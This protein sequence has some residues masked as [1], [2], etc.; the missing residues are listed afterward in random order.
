VRMGGIDFPELL[1]AARKEGN[2][3]VFAGAGVSIPPPSNYPDFTNLAIKVAGGA[4][5][6]RDKEPI[7][8]F[9]GRLHDR[10]VKVH[11][12][13]RQILTDPESKPNSLHFDLLRLFISAD[14]MR[15]VTTNFD[16]HFSTAV[17]EV[18]IDK[19]SCE[20]H[21]AP[22][23]PLGHSFSGIVYLHGGVN[24][25]PQHLVLTDSDFGRA[26]LTEGWARRFIQRV[27]ET[28]TVLFVGYSHNDP[29]MNYL[30]R[31]FTP[32][33]GKSRRF[34]LTPLGKEGSWEY[35]GIVPV[36][37]NPSAG[38]SP[39]SSLPKALSAWSEFARLGMLDKEHLIK[40]TV[41]LPP[42]IDPEVGD[43]IEDSLSE[44]STCRF[45]TRH[46]DSVPWLKWVE[47]K[48][49]LGRLFDPSASLTHIDEELAIWI[50]ENFPF[51]HAGETL[52]LIRRQ[53]QRL[54][55]RLWT[56]IA[57]KLSRD[58]SKEGN[59]EA[60]R[61]WVAVLI[62]MRPVGTDCQ[63]LEHL[64]ASFTFPDDVDVALL[65]F[66]YLTRPTL[67]LEHDLLR[68]LDETAP[69][70][71]VQF[72]IESYGGGFWLDR[73]WINFFEPNLSAL[74]EKL[75][76]IIASQFQLAY[77]LSQADSSI[78]GSWDTLSLSR[79]LI[80]QLD[81]GRLAGGLGVLIDAAFGVVKWN[82]ANRP[83]R[84]DALV[85]IWFSSDSFLLKRLAILAVALSGHWSGDRRLTW[86]L[87]NDL[88]YARG[89]K[90]E[91]FMILQG[92]YPLSSKDVRKEALVKVN[93]GRRPVPEGSENT[94]EY[95]K[96]NLIYWLHKSDPTCPL[97]QAAFQ[98]VQ[99][100]NPNFGT[101]EHPDLDVSFHAFQVALQSPRSVEELL[102]N[103]PNTQIDFLLTYVS[104]TPFG[105]NREGLV[106]NVSAAAIR[107]YEWSRQL[108]GALLARDAIKAD[109][110]S[111]LVRAWAASELRNDAWKEVLTL[112]DT[113][114]RLHDSLASEIANLLEAGIKK[115][116]Q[117]IPP[118]CFDLI[119]DLSKRLWATLRT[120]SKAPKP[121]SEKTD[122]VM[123]AIN[124]PA[125]RLTLFWLNW[126]ARQRRE[127]TANWT[128]IPK[129]LQ[130]TLEEVLE[131]DSYAGELAWVL[132][133]S[134][135]NLFFSADET[136]TK[137]SILPH[138]DWTLDAERAVLAFHGFLTWGQQTEPLLPYLLPAYKTAFSHMDELGKIRERFI[139][140]LAGLAVTSSLNPM[141]DGWLALFLLAAEKKD[142]LMWAMHV[143]QYLRG[144]YDT[145][146]T[147]AWDNWVKDYWCQRLLGLPV[148]LESPE[149]GAMVEWSLFLG[150]GFPKV[151]EVISNGP[152]FELKDSFVLRELADTKYPDEFPTA[153]GILLLAILRNMMGAPFDLEKAEEVVRRI[154]PRNASRSLLKDIC[155]ELGR[156]GYPLATALEKW[157][158]DQGSL[159]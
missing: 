79:N 75:E 141:K 158:G 14:K 49:L 138:F 127:A 110:W 95:E 78:D 132:L 59:R 60:K 68:E 109:L 27:F 129:T 6:L 125:G 128:G 87:E 93:L 10:K 32:E 65:V 62:G 57:R 106:E 38:E 135:L 70:E 9:L 23:L 81:H 102:S 149:L 11:E 96:Y 114:E 101:R 140:Y 4:L 136:W 17:E 153:S 123:R 80:E 82:I 43:F 22:A 28:F 151:A 67:H 111:A 126:L 7:D 47:D 34:A 97:A 89:L 131:D 122:W 99:E 39:H 147:A 150:E 44:I 52:S 46:A 45:F 33:M 12:R 152:S 103:P 143:Q 105:S 120:Q 16:V 35:L 55:P 117:P 104:E 118:E 159:D 69:K 31:G 130:R 91:V 37:Y 74:S 64:A 98:G 18:F 13:V 134:Q 90:H 137:K 24:K 2:L 3:V 154:A 25:P 50:A 20:I 112:L 48:K 100:A 30:A 41:A 61:R 144:S 76:S 115:S 83:N 5:E 63:S 29:V 119:D 156:L 145:A 116:P 124:H 92:A 53:G 19:P 108:A 107:N 71:N 113:E 72:R 84:A 40:T 21:Y 86:L 133:A 8:H 85:E 1:L 121:A 155:N 51:K 88:L 58:W 73:L 148:P 77:F 139:E 54:N 142:H 26:Y 94:A 36:A 157:T 66:E 146:R 15:L 42:P 56:L